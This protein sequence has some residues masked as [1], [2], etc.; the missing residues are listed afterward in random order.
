M[1]AE[2]GTRPVYWARPGTSLKTVMLA[3]HNTDVAP[4]AIFDE[5][6]RFVGAIGVRNVLQAVLKRPEP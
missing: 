6:D 5:S 4:V 3:I 2:E 1:P